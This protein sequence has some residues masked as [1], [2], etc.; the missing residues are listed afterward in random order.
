MRNKWNIAVIAVV[1]I[2]LITIIAICIIVFRL[3][4]IQETESVVSTI[5]IVN[6]KENIE[7]EEIIKVEKVVLGSEAENEIKQIPIKDSPYYIKVNNYMNVVNIYAKDENDSYSVPV[8]VLLCSTGTDTPKPSSKYKITSYKTRWNAMQ[9]GVWAQYATQI[10][11][12]ILFHS[13]P[14]LKKDPSTLEYWAYDRLGT[15]A[16][17]GCI[18]LTVEDAKWIYDNIPV[19]TVVE[20]YSDSD[21][22]PLGKP[23]AQ[24]ISGNTRCRG[25]DPTDL[26]ERNPWRL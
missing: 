23:S 14:Y 9:G 20:F 25:W 16:S 12:N 18:R 22:G 13:V 5:D 6:Q 10:V 19:G 4:I 24:K 15:K 11:G 8:K 17:A 3:Q 1:T 21:P 26:D 7:V 2:F